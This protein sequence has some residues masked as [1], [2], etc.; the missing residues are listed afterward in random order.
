MKIVVLGGGISGLFSGL[1][2][3]RDGHAVTL[4]ERDPAPVPHEPAGAWED[5]SR[6][7]VAQFRQPHYLQP[8]GR[9]LLEEELP[10][11]A[12]ALADAGG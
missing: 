3:A 5:W 7:G 9:M 1:L 10:D 4:V 8:R 2:L 12:A 11:V 6:E